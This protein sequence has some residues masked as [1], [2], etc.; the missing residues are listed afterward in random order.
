MFFRVSNAVIAP[1]LVQDLRLN[2]E[3]LGILGGAFFYSFT[4]LQ[5]P[6]GP[7]LDR[8]SPRMV[9]TFFP[10]IGALGAFLFASGET[11]SAA[12]W[13]RL[14]IGA[15]MACVLM[16]TMKVFILRFPPERFATLVG[17]FMSI[18]T[19]GN[20]LAAS[21]LAYFT[22]VIGWRMTFILAGGIT[23]LLAFLAFWILGG[24]K[25]SD[26]SV[27]SSPSEP[28]IGIL[29]SI[30]LVLGS[31]AFWQLGTIAFFRYG[32]SV[33]LQGLWLGPYLIDIK[34]YSPIQTG[35]ILVLF[36]IGQIVG[37][38]IS[39]HLSD[40]T[41]YSKKEVAI[42]GLIL[43]SLCLIPLTG[44]LRIESLFWHG[45]LFFFFG[46]F[47][48]FG[49]LIYAHA[50]ELYPITISGT[51]MTLVNFFT[52]AGAAIFMPAMGRII[53][54]FPR[55]NNVYQAKAYH[56]SF[57]VCFLTMVA[58]LIFYSFSKPDKP[59]HRVRRS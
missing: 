52:M 35:N 15:G 40:R 9:M 7:M 53:E 17:I 18:G 1:N 11:F 55:I 31:L 13:G 38:P 49:I 34:G 33:G 45:L 48:G 22:S 10:L 16:G 5:I 14:L 3:T 32:T 29:Q 26:E 2:A 25:G 23:T 47:G 27:I 58:S 44:V 54:F 39:G 8:I 37:G 12:L 51:A 43:Y 50:K 57:F 6:L 21:P 56:F 4:L 36:A 24:E 20:V 30:R 28:K 46:F 19:C 59:K 41:Y 42:W